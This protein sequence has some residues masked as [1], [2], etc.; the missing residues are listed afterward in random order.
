MNK[1]KYIVDPIFPAGRVH[2][3]GASTAVDPQRLILPW[4]SQSNRDSTFLGYPSRPFKHCYVAL[5]EIQGSLEEKLEKLGFSDTIRAVAIDQLRPLT[6]EA[7]AQLIPEDTEV[8]VIGTIAVLVEDNIE[9][10]DLVSTLM[11]K[12]QMVA[13]F[14]NL[15]IIGV[16]EATE[17][18]SGRERIAG[19]ALWTNGVG[20]VVTLDSGSRPDNVTATIKLRNAEPEVVEITP[21]LS[22]HAIEDYQRRWRGR[23]PH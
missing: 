18:Y 5:E 23:V 6:V 21:T 2:L 8:L 10:D 3:I 11:Y 15:T 22:I 16:T 20:T 14:R 12:L 13:S 19:S 1:P 4:L 9:S 7:I 17:D